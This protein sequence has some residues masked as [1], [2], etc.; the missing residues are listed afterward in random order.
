[1]KILLAADGSSHTKIA[2]HYLVKHLDWFAGTPDIH[3]LHVQ[4]PLPYP[5]AEALVGKLAVR[6]LQREESEAAL[7]VAE[8]ELAVARVPYD[9]TWRV[10][11]VAKELARYVKAEGIDLVVMGSHGHGA[12]ANLALGSVATKCLATLDVPV[13]IVRQ[14]PRQ[15]PATRSATADA[16][17]PSNATP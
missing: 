8:R 7:A 3:V 11:D 13:M 10:G 16:S 15:N 6:E 4:P 17:V 1:M 5:R 9:S 12:L 2:A 14:A